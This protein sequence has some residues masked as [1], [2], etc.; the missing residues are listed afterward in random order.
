M[1]RRLTHPNLC[2]H[3]LDLL[4]LL[5]QLRPQKLNFLLLLCSGRL[6]ILLQLRDCHLLF[7]D[8]AM[9]FQKLIEQHRV[10]GVIADGGCLTI[11]VTRH[12]VRIY[13][14]D[15]LGNEPE[16]EWTGRFNLRFR[17]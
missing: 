1:L 11:A 3:L 10:D 16:P 14:F 5:L 4:C 9:L 12:E 17:I 6:K 15:V 13:L 7:R 2:A 8:L